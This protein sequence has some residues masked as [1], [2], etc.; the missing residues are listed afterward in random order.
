MCQ[1]HSTFAK[2]QWERKDKQIQ[3]KFA[4]VFATARRVFKAELEKISVLKLK[5]LYFVSILLFITEINGKY[6][7][8]LQ[9]IWEISKT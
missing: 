4:A 7:E 2:Y 1:K 3:A 8:F 9:L 6:G 5:K